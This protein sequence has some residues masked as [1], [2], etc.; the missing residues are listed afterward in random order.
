MFINLEDHSKDVMENRFCFYSFGRGML[1]SLA[2]MQ[3]FWKGYGKL[4]KSMG[5]C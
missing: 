5:H 1:V 3:D 2:P 4:P